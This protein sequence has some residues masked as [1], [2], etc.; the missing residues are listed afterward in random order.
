MP[1]TRIR[2]YRTELPRHHQPLSREEFTT[3]IICALPLEYDAVCLVFDEFW[4][5]D[6]DPYGTAPGDINTYT[7]GRIGDQNVVLT[8]LQRMGKASAASAVVSMRLSYTGLRQAFLVGICGGVPNTQDRTE[9]MLGDVVIS[10]MIVQYDFGK[11]YPDRFVRKYTTTEAQRSDIQGF[12]V[13]AETMRGRNKLRQQASKFLSRLQD[14]ATEQ[15]CGAKYVYPGI[16]KDELFEPSYRHKHHESPSCICKECN[17][18]TSPVCDEALTASCNELGCNS[19]FLVQR[20]RSINNKSR[21]QNTNM[22]NGMRMPAIH[23][24][25]VASGD[26]VMKSGVDRDTIARKD[27]VIAFEMEAA[28]IWEEIPCLLVKGVSDYADSHKHSEWQHFAAAT[29]A[30]TMSALLMSY[31]EKEKTRLG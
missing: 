9:I 10:K 18:L 1:K 21:E 26:T 25:S 31:S 23:V 22:P 4:D 24:G 19:R 17:E 29:A 27:G 20:A 28:G 15:E 13:M 3:A 16:A 11:K 6:G 2:T 5:E 7:T 30:A 14:N 12:V 8:L